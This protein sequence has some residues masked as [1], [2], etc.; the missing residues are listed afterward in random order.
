MSQPLYAG[1]ASPPAA[2]PASREELEGLV[3]R[4]NAVAV[5]CMAMENVV[6]G[7]ADW[8]AAALPAPASER[9]LDSLAELPQM[10]L[11]PQMPPDAAEQLRQMVSREQRHIVDLI[12]HQ[13]RARSAPKPGAGG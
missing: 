9:F 6:R 12:R 11:D 8:L 4:A 5:R 2:T 13:N 7:L 1:D 10:T 3:R